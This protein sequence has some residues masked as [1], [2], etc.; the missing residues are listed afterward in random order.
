M[1]REPTKGQGFQKTV[2]FAVKQAN[3]SERTIEHVITARTVDR[4]GDVV[5]PRGVRSDNFR[6]NPVV[7]FGHNSWNFPVAKNVALDVTDDQIVALT[8]FAGLEQANAEAETAYRMARDGFLNAW[9]IGFMP[10][11]W[12]EDKALPGQDGWWFKE[13]E[14]YEYSLVPIPSNPEALSRMAKGYGLPAGATEK[15]FLDAVRKDRKPYFDFGAAMLVGASKSPRPKT[16]EVSGDIKD[17]VLTA[18]TAIHNAV[19]VA[20]RAGDYTTA[21]ALGP[22]AASLICVIG[23][24][25][26]TAGT[27]G[28]YPTEPTPPADG[29]VITSAIAEAFKELSLSGR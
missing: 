15:D 4:D 20:L 13:T 26:N 1:K 23:P 19:V 28:G 25:E 17:A 18:L 29:P 22:V 21:D 9:S 7:L 14:L 2:T 27:A 24:S 10:I 8:Q 12:S 11:T 16:K 5:E 6:K 3:D